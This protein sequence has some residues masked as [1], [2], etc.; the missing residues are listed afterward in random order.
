MFV[1]NR[2]KY[3]V[4]T[5]RF[6]GKGEIYAKARP[7]Y[8]EKLFDYI[9]N[10]LKITEGSVFADVGSGTGIFTK[11]LIDCG[12]RI[13]AV[14]PNRDMRR[15][16]EEKLNGN[17]NF[18]SVAGS[19]KKTNLP[20]NSVDCVSAAQAFHWFNPEAFK[21][22][23]RRILKP[24]GKVFIVY[25]S[26]TE[27]AEC[28]MALAELYYKYSP[29]FH[30]FSNGMSGEKCLSFFS[31]NGVVFRTDNTLTYD[32]QSYVNRIL[33]SS[34]SLK[35]GDEKYDDYL[36]G[37]NAV[38]DKFSKDGFILIPNETVAYIGEV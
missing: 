26:K 21:K 10:D 22:E 16:A 27:S 12:Y 20:E 29:D 36:K 19:E 38:F 18:T 15:K 30:G 28:T 5:N 23:C 4:Y 3:T 13:F 24:G 35:D 2:L 32:R 9:K 14:E 8:A 6:D 11:Q 7:K 17:E 37:I 31:K 1:L 25:N 33:S 34:Y